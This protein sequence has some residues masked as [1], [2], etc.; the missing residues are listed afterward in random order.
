M[1]TFLGA[2]RDLLQY[3]YHLGVFFI[4]AVLFFRCFPPEGLAGWTP[5]ALSL[6]GCAL[7]SLSSEGL[8]FYVPTRTPA[9][10]DLALDQSGAVLG[11]VIWMRHVS[12]KIGRVWR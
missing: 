9:L 2:P 10:R 3:P 11:V 4:L 6:F 7:V 5:A 12:D 8:Q 1:K